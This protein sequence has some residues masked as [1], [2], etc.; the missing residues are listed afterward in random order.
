VILII[1][2]VFFVTDPETKSSQIYLK[3]RDE[4]KIGKNCVSRKDAKDA[5]N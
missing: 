5:K 4:E 3:F 1:S 2:G